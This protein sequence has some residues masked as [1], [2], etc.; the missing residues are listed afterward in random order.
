MLFYNFSYSKTAKNLN[1]DITSCY[2]KEMK[3]NTNIIKSLFSIVHNHRGGPYFFS[4]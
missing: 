1:I 4:E 3:P 2:V